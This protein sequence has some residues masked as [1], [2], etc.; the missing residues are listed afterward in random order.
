MNA[1]KMQ[2]QRFAAARSIGVGMCLLVK[3]LDG[4]RLKVGKE[5]KREKVKKRKPIKTKLLKKNRK[6]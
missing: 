5:N 6:A 3:R 4:G 1:V 2:K